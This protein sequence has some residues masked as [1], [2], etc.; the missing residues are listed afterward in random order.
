MFCSTTLGKVD[1]VRQLEPQLYIDDDISSIDCVNALSTTGFNKPDIIQCLPLHYNKD[2]YHT[3][4]C[5]PSPMKTLL[6][7]T[8]VFRTFDYWARYVYMHVCISIYVCIH[9][10]MYIYICVYTC[11][12]VYLY[13][14]VFIIL[15]VS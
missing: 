7:T 1:I 13:M 11:M 9:A 4:N 10:C 15:C 5:I 12:Y 2:T 8:P 14:C 6:H 3:T